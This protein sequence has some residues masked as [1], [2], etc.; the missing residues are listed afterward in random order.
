MKNAVIR[1]IRFL[2]R[3][4]VDQLSEPMRADIA[5]MR[6]DIAEMR[7][8]IASLREE[9]ATIQEGLPP[10]VEELQALSRE[11]RADFDRLAETTGRLEDTT[12]RNRADTEW[13]RAEVAAQRGRLERLLR[14]FDGKQAAAQDESRH[15]LLSKELERL[16]GEEYEGFE[17]VFRG[18]PEVITERL[19]PY[20]NDVFTIH[21]PVLD[22]GSGR[23]EW[24]DLLRDKG[25]AAAG[26]ELNEV[27]A[28]DAQRRGHEVSVGDGVSELRR[29]P[30]AS[31]G[32]VTAFHVVEHLEF[33]AIIELTDAALDALEPG[34]V[35]IFETPNPMNV[36]VGCAEFYLD[37]T[38]VR[39]LHPRLLEYVVSSR[40]FID[41][42][43]RFFN[44]GSD[45]RLK[46]PEGEHQA[47]V[48]FLNREMFG[49]EDYAVIARKPPRPFTSDELGAR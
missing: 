41:V 46:V 13:N 18:N 26:I 47:V 22:I 33:P 40:G 24:L 17:R 31:L 25:I 9:L 21:G 34:G 43:T 37:P 45:A 35:L 11:L 1:L 15:D 49:A 14:M 2:I 42:E 44:R 10:A 8:A 48:E 7:W 39:P 27:F 38:H 3:H 19:R 36:A 20:L 30:K 4:P 23:G 16:L 29:R 6:A 28:E 32:A 5:E 12:E